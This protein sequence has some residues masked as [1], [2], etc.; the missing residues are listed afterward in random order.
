MLALFCLLLC[1]FKKKIFF[2]LL[3]SRVPA[4]KC[5][6]RYLPIKDCLVAT[7]IYVYVHTQ[8]ERKYAYVRL[9]AGLDLR[10]YVY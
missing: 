6:Q 9:M 2:V 5:S 10:I 7:T 4:M 1:S 3:I 8:V